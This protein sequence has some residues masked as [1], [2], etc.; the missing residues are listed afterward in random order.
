MLQCC[1]TAFNEIVGLLHLVAISETNIA[2]AA[3]QLNESIMSTVF[4]NGRIYASSTEGD[5]HEWMEIEGAKVKVRGSL[6]R[7]QS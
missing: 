4:Y 1:I 5:V 2:A 7:H 6:F 3:L